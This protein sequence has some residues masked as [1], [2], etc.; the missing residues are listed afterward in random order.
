MTNRERAE[1][2]LSSVS[3]DDSWIDAS[4]EYTK[5]KLTELLDSVAA[6]AGECSRVHA[7]CLDIESGLLDD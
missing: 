1:T 2:F 6:E 4:S 3:S 5:K 7:G